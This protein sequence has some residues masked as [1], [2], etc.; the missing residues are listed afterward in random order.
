MAPT[1]N[2]PTGGSD[3]TQP[4]WVEEVNQLVALI[5]ESQIARV[6]EIAL[7]QDGAISA[8]VNQLLQLSTG[9]NNPSSSHSSDGSNQL[10][11]TRAVKLE[12]PKFVGNDPKGWIF[13]E[14]EYFLFHRISDEAK[15]QVAALNMVKAALS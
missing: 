9:K 11:T 10:A 3:L 14:E 7:W 12:F 1:G 2:A 15:P 6:T 4:E 5:I 8:I 13:Q